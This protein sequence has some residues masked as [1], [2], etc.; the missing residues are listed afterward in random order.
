VLS[1]VG[2]S[3]LQA[4]VQAAE[5]KR[6]SWLADAGEACNAWNSKQF[7]DSQIQA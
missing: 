7:S 3:A 5:E 1:F 2:L 6:T 4:G